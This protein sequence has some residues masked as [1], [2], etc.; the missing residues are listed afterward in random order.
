MGNWKLNGI[1]V[2]NLIERIALVL[3]LVACGKTEK[4]VI[5]RYPHEDCNLLSRFESEPD[6]VK[7]E[8][9]F[10]YPFTQFYS[11]SEKK[12]KISRELFKKSPDYPEVNLDFVN[13]FDGFSPA[14]QIMF[15]NPK[16]FSR[17]GLPSI[18]DSVKVDS[19]VQLIEWESGERVPIFVEP[20]A[21]ANPPFQILYIRPV[22]RMKTSSRYVVVIKKGV[23]TADESDLDSPLL[24][25]AI[26]DGKDVKFQGTSESPMLWKKH[27]LEI[28]DFLE[29]Q[30]IRKSE[31]VVAWDF[32]TASEDK[33]LK[34]HL[35]Q[36]KKMVYQ[37][38]GLVK[39]E[40][41]KVSESYPYKDKSYLLDEY[42]NFIKYSV[43]GTFY[44]RDYRTSEEKP[45]EFFLNIPKCV[46]SK[47]N[48]NKKVGILI[49]GHGLF[50]SY[51]ELDSH[52]LLYLADYLCRPIIATNWV[53]IDEI[54]RGE[55]FGKASSKSDYPL[56]IIQYLAFNLKQGH[57]NFLTLALLVKQNNFWDVIRQYISELPQVDTEDVVYYGI[58]NGAIQGG[59]FMALTDEIKR[60]VLDVGAGIWTSLLERNRSWDF[61]RG[62]LLPQGDEWEIEIKKVIA[63]G[64]SVFDIVDPITFAP[65]IIRGSDMYEISPKQILY[66]EALYDEQVA[67][68]ATRAYVRTAGIAGIKKLVQ[69]EVGI[70]EID[71][72][73]E[74]MESGYLQVDPKIP[75]VPKYQYMNVSLQ[76]LG[77]PDPLSLV[78]RKG[79]P[80]LKDEGAY[81]APHEVPRLVPQILE[82]QKRFY[83][84]GR[85]Y[86]TCSNGICDPD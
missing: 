73:V 82:M 9:F 27:L 5:I 66:R 49:F 16:G 45:Y 4:E 8:C 70:P 83:E 86:Q 61:L 21:R 81:T 59:I 47:K 42:R 12:L 36:I 85:I 20:D 41:K 54:A 1:R 58:S 64:Q 25:K 46:E 26:L 50:G 2:L 31:V 30:G 7:D 15:W 67:N 71:P 37:Y 34:E 18:S 84:E 17:K 77:E 69:S 63:V 48:E 43:E 65:Y 32:P 68:F 76:F 10:P 78:V 39:F 24:F 6:A 75:T 44:V 23:R 53:G 60:G 56:G 11:Q 80:L 28:L 72:D 74:K 14:N 3:I 79:W 35:I 52:H 33:I 57:A 55:V 51:K 29:K 19:P 38:K 22:K 40:I 13:S 62:F